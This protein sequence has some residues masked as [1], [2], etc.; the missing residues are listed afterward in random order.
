MAI[1]GRKQ[2]EELI[3]TILT[4]FILFFNQLPYIHSTYISRVLTNAWSWDGQRRYRDE[5]DLDFYYM[6]FTERKRCK[7]NLDSVR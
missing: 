6:E 7:H 3:C 1:P 4:M 2:S 5:G